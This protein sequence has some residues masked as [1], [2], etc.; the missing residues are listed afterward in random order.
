MKTYENLICP[1]C[2]CKLSQE[3]GSLYCYYRHCY[4]LAS[5]GYVNLV[6]SGSKTQENSGDNKD[7]M[8]SRR[9]IMDKGYYAKLVEGMT[10]VIAKYPNSNILDIGCGEGYVVGTIA[11]AFEGSEIRGT[12]LAKNAVNLAAKRYKNASFIV[13]NSASLPILDRSVDVCTAVFTPVYFSEVERVLKKGG[14]FIK[15]NPAPEHLLDLKKLLY[16]DEV[17][18]NEENDLSTEEFELVEQF[19][20]SDVFTARGEEIKDLLQMTPYYYHT[21]KE[22]LA[23]VEALEEVV[24]KLSYDVKVYKLK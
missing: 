17:Y 3:G 19:V 18:L 12:D 1:R 23:R 22:A 7:M 9:R 13:A 24:T 8:L 2:G 10:S 15:V 20:V 16:A 11:K 4:D 5:A 14:A 21:P 6:L